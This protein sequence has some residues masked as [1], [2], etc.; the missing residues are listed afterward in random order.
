MVSVTI[1][2]ISGI[3]GAIAST[4]EVMAPEIVETIPLKLSM[5]DGSLST[6]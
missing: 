3:Y 5:M 4:M 2:V 1:F 6:V